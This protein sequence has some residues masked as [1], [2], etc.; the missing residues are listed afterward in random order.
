MNLANL[1]NVMLACLV[2]Q[3]AQA[4][5]AQADPRFQADY[6]AGPV[7]LG[8]VPGWTCWSP[9][10][11]PDGRYL[12]TGWYSHTL[13]FVDLA[14]EGKVHTIETANSI[15]RAAVSP[16]GKQLVTAE[17]FQGVKVRDF[18]SGKVLKTL[19]PS[20]GLPA[21]EVGFAGDGKLVVY[22]WS[23]RSNKTPEF[24]WQLSVWN[25]Q[26]GKE[27]GYPT[28]EVRTQNVN[29]QF[30]QGLVGRGQWLQTVEQERIDEGRYLTTKSVRYTDPAT[31]KATPPLKLRKFD[32]YL[33]GLSPDGRTLLAMNVGDPPRLLD[34]TTGKDRL[35]PALHR[36][37]VNTGAISPD[38][39][40]LAT[41]SGVSSCCFTRAKLPAP[42]PLAA[43]TELIV[44]DAARLKPVAV[45]GSKE[46][47]IDFQQVGF[48]PTGQY[49]W[50]ITE[51]RDLLIWGRLPAPAPRQD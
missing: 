17:W 10:M 34:L 41:A 12:I 45:L 23:T 50:A 38:G 9:A 21:S 16:D 46:K 30:N 5:N 42:L 25:W 35:L 8:K 29:A 51:E 7:Q 2:L 22:C 11:T 40:L 39:K 28:Q 19:W 15:Q 31:G 48:S 13:H 14:L 26:D 44:W 24:D 36:Q 27:I 47:N 3:E 20:G 32:N 37:F 1:A 6:W 18:K 49:L 43:P 4:D 33:F